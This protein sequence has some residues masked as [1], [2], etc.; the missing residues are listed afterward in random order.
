MNSVII[1]AEK[2]RMKFSAFAIC[3]LIFSACSDSSAPQDCSRFKTGRYRHLSEH[4]GSVTTII[5]NDSFQ[6]EKNEH[7]SVT[8]RTAVKWISD[9]EY[10]LSYV[11]QEVEAGGQTMSA[12]AK[13]PPVTVKILKTTPRYYLFSAV[14]DEGETRLADTME[15]V[16]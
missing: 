6:F 15:I 7:M 3:V 4:D 8:I 2:N 12:F 1:K 13:M 5:R 10:R 9:C 16:E 11:D 14:T